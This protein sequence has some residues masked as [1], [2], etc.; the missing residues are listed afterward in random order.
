MSK[1]TIAIDVDDVLAAH[2][3]EFVV[4]SNQ[5]FGTHLTIEDYREHWGEMWNISHEETE[6]RAALWR[7]PERINSFSKLEG[8]LDKRLQQ[9]SSKYDLVVV[10]ARPSIWQDG[11]R[12]WLELHY[13]DIFKDVRLVPVWTNETQQTKAEVCNEIGAGYLIDDS[14]RHCNLAAQSGINAL[15]FGD[16]AWNRNEPIV[17]GVVRVKDWKAVMEYFDGRDG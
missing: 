6:Q 10:T 15:L 16:Y 11:T 14:P 9:L 17:P 2:A 7:V 3:S 13:K 1:P 5:T 8:D 12:S 4:F